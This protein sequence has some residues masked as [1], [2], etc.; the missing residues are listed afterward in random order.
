MQQQRQNP[1]LANV[2]N[3]GIVDTARVQFLER[4][5]AQ[6]HNQLQQIQRELSESIAGGGKRRTRRITA[7]Q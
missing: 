2:S 7:E 3:N 5:N 6:L 1:P 4:E